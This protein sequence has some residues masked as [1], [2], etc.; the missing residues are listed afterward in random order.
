MLPVKPERKAHLENYA[1][2]HGLSTAEATQCWRI[3]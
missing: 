3:S 1:Q 2:R